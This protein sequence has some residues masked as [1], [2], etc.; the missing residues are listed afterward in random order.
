MQSHEYKSDRQCVVKF[1]PTYI[2]ME[3]YVIKTWENLHIHLIKIFESI[4]SVFV[5]THYL[6]KYD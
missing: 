3:W 5:P 6:L 1:P 2:L 4:Y